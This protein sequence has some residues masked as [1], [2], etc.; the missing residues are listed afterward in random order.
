M[1][2]TAIAFVVFFIRKR[3]IVIGRGELDVESNSKS[4]AAAD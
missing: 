1:A 2:I 4:T 3:W